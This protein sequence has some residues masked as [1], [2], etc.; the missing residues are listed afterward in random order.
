MVNA[1]AIDA[2]LLH[3][4]GI[5]RALGRVDEGIVRS[6]LV[7]DTLDEELGAILV[8]ELVTVGRDGGDGVDG[9]QEGESCERRQPHDCW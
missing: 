5:A 6:Q 2:E 3:Q 1:D 8:E 7:G 4:R 9:A